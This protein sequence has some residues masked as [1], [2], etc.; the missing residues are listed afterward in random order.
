MTLTVVRFIVCLPNVTRSQ[1][2][3]GLLRIRKYFRS[4]FVPLDRPSEGLR[5]DS[6]VIYR[7]SVGFARKSVATDSILIVKMF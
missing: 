7:D 1:L 4:K 6:T 5:L 3:S 2:I